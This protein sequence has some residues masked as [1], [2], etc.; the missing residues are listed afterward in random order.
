MPPDNPI[1]R[2]IDQQPDV[3]QASLSA[4]STQLPGWPQRAPSSIALVG[5]GSS[6]NALLVAAPEFRRRAPVTA[7]GPRSFLKGL[8]R[9]AET[10]ALVVVLSQ[11]GLSTTSVEAAR[12]AHAAGLAT[13][14]MTAEQGSPIAALGTDL[15][16]L[17][18]G[19]EPVGPKTKG[20]A[21]SVAGLSVLAAR[22]AGTARPAFDAGRFAALIP[23]ARSAAEALAPS[24]DDLDCLLVGGEECHVGTALEGSLK[25]TEMAGVPAAAYPTEEILHGRLHGLSE[26]SLALLIVANPAER[27]VA[28]QAA[29]TMAARGPRV[30]LVNLTADATR[31]DWPASFDWDPR[32][33]GA[34]AAIL[35]FQ[36]LAVTLARRRGLAPEAMKYPGLSQALQIKSGP[37]A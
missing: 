27:A 33:L 16:V 7:L 11:T 12:R 2:Y 18:V 35:P 23:M 28:V 19:P 20:Y 17:P 5:S 9:M 13:L 14:V 8:D 24:L 26:R 31:F 15:A 3:I 37:S 30:R 21:A 10:G 32:P 25:V 6:L 34:L 4:V 36:C 1:D 22:L 29:K